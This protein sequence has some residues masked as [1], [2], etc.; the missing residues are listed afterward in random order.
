M[1]EVKDINI[2]KVVKTF[3]ILILVVVIA[4]FIFI[5]TKI[6]NLE[7]S[8][9]SGVSRDYHAGCVRWYL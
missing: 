1:G 2:K 5:F 4:M 9:K 3:F 8:A 7:R 6:K